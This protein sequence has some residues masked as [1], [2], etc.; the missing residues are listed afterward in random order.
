MIELLVV[1]LIIGILAAIALPQYRKAV[2]KSRVAEAIMN[3]KSLGY[4]T[5]RY[6]LATGTEPT[7]LADLDIEINGSLINPSFL[8]NGKFVYYINPNLQ[9]ITACM[10]NPDKTN[11]NTTPWNTSDICINY[12]M[13]QRAT[14]PAGSFTCTY[15]KVSARTSYASICNPN[16]AA[17]IYDDGT[18]LYFHI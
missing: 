17:S 8:T 6:R 15:R 12:W 5:E 10:I 16:Q 1:V 9:D 4:A 2:E 7:A 11:I 13:K 3:I 14:I 18:F